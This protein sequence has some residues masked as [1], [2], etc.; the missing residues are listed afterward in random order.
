[1]STA[2][3]TELSKHRTVRRHPDG[4]R[5]SALSERYEDAVPALL[6]RFFSAADDFLFK[7]AEKNTVD[8]TDYFEQ[9]RVLR[10]RKV[11]VRAGILSDLSDWL[12][13][14]AQQLKDDEAEAAYSSSDELTLMDDSALERTLAVDS[15][16]NRT[17]ERSG[18]QWLA[19]HE[20]MMALTCEKSLRDKETPFNPGALGQLVLR[21]LDTMGMPFKT[22]L[23]LFRL[24][25]DLA[26]SQLEAFYKNSNTW[27]IEEG[28]LPNLRLIQSASTS[29]SPVNA[30]TIAQIS[31][32]LAGFQPSS[33]GFAPGPGSQGQYFAGS[34]GGFSGGQSVGGGQGGFS[35]SG[36][37]GYPQSG[38]NAN[39]VMIDPA[40]WQ[41]ML[42][43]MSTFQAQPAPAPQQM[44]DLKQ[45]TS[46]QAQSISKQA[47]G[48]LEAG[49]VSL[50]AMLFEYILDDEHLSAHM[51]QLLA[52]LQIPV[53]KVA[54]I[55][56]TFFTDTDHSARLLLNRMARAATGWKPDA[57]IENDALLDGMEKIVSELNHDFDDDLTIFDRLLDEFSELLTTY[58]QQQGAA[59][60]QV[61]EVEE[62]EYQTHQQQDRARIFMDRLLDGVTDLPDTVHKL[63]DKHWYRLMKN[64][65][66]QQGESKAWQ[67]SARIAR[68]LIWSLQ[69]SIQVTHPSR[70]EKVVPKLLQGFEQGLKS[71]NLSDSTIRLVLDDIQNH[72]R[73][74]EGD[75]NES[76]WDAQEKLD[77]F[78]QQSELAEAVVE[79][80]LP[81]PVDEPVV[82]LKNADLSYYLDQ[83][84]S[85]T[86]G[87]WFDIEQSDGSFE[88]GQ[89]T[90]I[91]GTG[92]KYVFT[93][94][95]GNKVAERS[96][97]GL[98]M[99]MRN[100]QFIPIAED[101]LFDRMIDTLV[102]ELGGDPSKQ[103]TV[104]RH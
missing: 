51:K 4:R 26:I 104:T 67:T 66:D 54:I 15:F 40:I 22:V 12:Q 65:F 32:S 93:D 38:G 102:D 88:R 34:G 71:A 11:E 50:V 47:E 80:P 91:I 5:L 59:V 53:I 85:M 57:N 33:G 39:G 2:T 83:V 78:E 90:M 10:R 41:Q 77:R 56:K 52:R 73:L 81:L 27:L 62:Q 18:D 48:T 99:A 3:V 60:D 64:I 92:S 35:G 19:F 20:R 98:A 13:S 94:Y 30:Q 23:M 14:G 103:A 89:L 72:H 58:E 17:L 28:I 37:A 16:M 69:P 1:M 21:R 68:E 96:A 49:T 24:F 45:W 76:V 63:L 74:Y 82:Q 87:L 86:E 101:P 61:R 8:S 55:D 100:D 46:H 84:E 43:S 75:I 29:S 70:F 36:S 9:L 95:Q 44:D 42:Q 25:D 97:I 31:A 7:Q 6:D 79:D